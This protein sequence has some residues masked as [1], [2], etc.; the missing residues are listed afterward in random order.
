LEDKN[1]ALT[2][3]HAQMTETLEQQTAT[4][5]ILGVISLSPTDTQR[6]FDTIVRN[7]V[8]LCGAI[9]GTV[10]LADGE[11][12]HLVA[13]S[14]LTPEHLEQLKARYP[15]ALTHPGAIPTAIRT[16]RVVRVGDLDAEADAV[17][18]EVTTVMLARGVRS[19]LVVPMIRQ[20]EAIGSINMTHRDVGA[21]TDRQVELLKTFADQA[22][23]AIE[24]VRLFKELQARNTD[25]A[26]ALDRQTATSEILRVISQSQTEVQPVFDAIVENALRLFRAWSASVLRLDGQLIHLIATRGGA[27]WV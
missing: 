20:A 16:R 11:V 4:S 1:S 26:E 3:A 18:A 25:L 8:Q 15:R 12:I 13:H 24:N 27:A 5:E 14:G 21:F 2:K 17:S 10:S 19:V 22:V 23:I 6:V 7:A 9:Y